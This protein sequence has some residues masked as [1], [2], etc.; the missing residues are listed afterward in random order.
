MKKQNGLERQVR[1]VITQ[2]NSPEQR[3]SVDPPPGGTQGRSAS[4]EQPLCGSSGEPRTSDLPR[5]SRRPPS[6][7]DRKDWH[8]VNTSLAE[9]SPGLRFSGPD[10]ALGSQEGWDN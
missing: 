2:S 3:N 1:T 9:L 6:R 7:R 10:T 5:S 8:N 4:G